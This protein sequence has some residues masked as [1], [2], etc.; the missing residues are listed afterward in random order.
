[1]LN[2]GG[3]RQPDASAEPAKLAQ[4]RESESV[5]T[6]K[7]MNS[8]E[9]EVLGD[10]EDAQNVLRVLGVVGYVDIL[11][12]A[13]VEPVRQAGSAG[14]NCFGGLEGVQSREA[15]DQTAVHVQPNSEYLCLEV[16]RQVQESVKLPGAPGTLLAELVDSY[17]PVHP[18]G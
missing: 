4:A 1:M 10:E 14:G 12:F 5:E 8:L 15:V 3:S 6:V 18:S 9:V 7:G 11:V 16:G 13:P 2:T 17:R